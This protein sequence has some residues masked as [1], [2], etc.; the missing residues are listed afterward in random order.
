MKNLLL[1]HLESL[2]YINYRLNRDM[3][4]TLYKL[5]SKGMIFDRYYSTA[6]STLMV[7]G[8]LLYGGM[9]QYEQCRSLNTIPEEYHYS[10]SLFDDLKSQGYH[11]ALYVHPEGGDRVGA[12]KRHIAGFQNEMI[13]KRNYRDFLQVLEEGMQHAPFALMACNYISNL[14]FNGYTDYSKYDKDTTP[15]EIGYRSLDTFVKDVMDILEKHNIC[16]STL[17]VLYGDHGDDY[18]THG[19]HQGLTHAI[20]P[21]ELLIHVPLFILDSSVKEAHISNQLVGTTDL[22]KLAHDVVV[23]NVALKDAI[24]EN[25][26]IVSR[27]EYAAQ[28]VRSE[29]FNKAY[30]LT[31]GH[32][33]LMVSNA[34]L[35]MY[36]VWMDGSCHNNL[37]RFFRLDT[38]YFLEICDAFE[39][40][41][42]H[43]RDY[44][45]ARTQRILRQNFYILWDSLY[46]KVLKL[47]KAGKL[48]EEQMIDEMKFFTINYKK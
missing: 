43:M 39:K 25:P 28:P 19:D 40:L 47:Y 46:K 10:S 27:N 4:P 1:V 32:Y 38:N 12:E 41:S 22:R 48:S 23:K 2:N 29:S 30:S 42:Y 20:E 33:M 26:W 7:I 13:L 21:N 5:E 31:D 37:L 17:V 18:W 14:S 9:E 6:T 36:D 11:T 44:L 8:D 3:F 15:W 34:G 16:D 35:E 45:S 24:P